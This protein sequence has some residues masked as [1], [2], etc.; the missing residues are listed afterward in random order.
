MA[1]T[2]QE[3]EEHERMIAEFLEKGGTIKQCD[4]GAVTEGAVTSVWKKR[5]PGR[6][7]ATDKKE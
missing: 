5:G 2:R 1:M 6:P 7:K 4:T 3:R